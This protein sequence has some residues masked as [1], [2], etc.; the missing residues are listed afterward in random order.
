MNEKRAGLVTFSVLGLAIVAAGLLYRPHRKHGGEATKAPAAAMMRQVASAANAPA[1]KRVMQTFAQ[2]PLSFE[3]E[4]ADGKSGKRFVSRGRGYA[5]EISGKGARLTHKFR[6]AAD[7]A[8]PEAATLGVPLQSVSNIRLSWLGANGGPQVAGGRKQRGQS[9]YLPSKDR[10]TWRQHVAHYGDVRI[11]KLYPGV[12]LKFHGDGQKLEFDYLVAAGADASVVRMGIGTPSLV[13]LNAQGQLEISDNGD[14]LVLEPPVAYQD[15]DGQRKA[16]QAEFVIAAGHEVRFALGDYD[17][18]RALVIDPVLSFA[19]QFGSSSNSS[20]ASDVAVDSTGN[21]YITGT[22]CD[23]DYPV[24]VGVLQPTGGSITNDQCYTGIITKLDPTASS[25]IYSTYIGSQNNITSGIRILPVGSG[26]ALVAGVTTAVDFPTTANA[27]DQTAHGGTCQYGPFLTNKPCTD[28][29][30]LQLSADGSSLVFSTYFGGSGFEVVSS[31]TLDGT[32][33]IY[34]A[35]ATNSADF[36]TTSGAVDTTFGGGVCQNGLFACSDGFVAKFSSDGSKLLES[37]YLGGDD[38]DFASGVALDT[39]GNIYVSGSTNSTNFP[40]TQG[41]YQ[42]THS[43]GANQPDVF[44]AKL[45]PDMKTLTYSTF[46]GGTGFDLGLAVKVDSTGAAYVTGSTGSADFPTTPASFQTSYAGPAMTFCDAELDGSDLNQPSCG[47]IFVSKLNPTGSALVYSTYIGGSGADIA[48]NAALDSSNDFWLLA[49][50]DS[51]DFPYTADAY[52]ASTSENVALVELSPDGK[53]LLFSTPLS[54]GTSG[55]ALALG[56]TIDSAN[57]IYVAGQATQFSPTPGTL[58]AGSNPD[59]FIAKFV[60][61]TARPGVQ[62]SA[63]SVSFLNASVPEG[64]ASAPQSVTL[65]NNGTAPL[66]LAITVPV[67]FGGTPATISEY[68]NCG[69][70]VA[71]GATCTINVV[72]QPPTNTT[73]G[74]GTITITDNAP[75]SPQSILVSGNTGTIDA[76]TFFPS[77]LTFTGQ[78]PGTTSAMQTSGIDTP[79]SQPGALEPFLAGPPTIS[80]PNVAD[81]KIDT[82]NCTVAVASHGCSINVNFAPAANATGTR[83]ASVTV[84]TNAPNSPQ[85]LNLTGTVSGGPFGVF[86]AQGIEVIPTML[87]LTSNNN[88]SVQNTGGAAL[89]ATGFAITG[90][91]ASDFAVTPASCNPAFTLQ[92]QGVCVFELAFT[93]SAHGTRTATLTLTDNEAT[94]AS[95]MVTGYGQD[96]TGPALSLFVSP[97]TGANSAAF[98]GTVLGTTGLGGIFVAVQNTTGTASAQITSTTITGDFAITNNQCTGAIAAGGS[99]TLNV[100]FTPTQTGSRTGI[101]TITTNAPGGQ[102]FTVNFTGTGLVEPQASVTP[103]VL[104]FTS[105]NVGSTSA[106]QT[107]TVKN[108]GNGVL[109]ISN[110]AVTGPFTQTTTCGATLAA[111]ASCTFTVKFAPTV[112]GPGSGTLTFAG[113]A[114]G[115]N[116]AVGLNGVGVTGPSAS[117]SPTSLTFGNQAIGTVSAPQTVTLSNAGS[118]SFA[119]SGVQPSENFAATS[120]CP[121]TLA[122]GAS[123]AI[124]VKFAPTGDVNPGFASGGEVFVTTSAP[125]SPQSIGV[126]GMA[127][128][129]TGAATNLVIVSSVNPSTAGQAVTFTVTVTPT[130]AGG[131]TPTGTISFLDALSGPAEIA[132]PVTLNAQG[133]ASV[134]T[135]TLSQGTHSIFVMYTGDATYAP[136]TSSGTL[137]TVAAATTT[138]VA[139]SQNPSTVGQSVTFTATTTSTAAGTITGSVTFFDGASQIS[140]PVTISGGQ[141]VLAITTLAQGTH[142]ITARYNGGP[143]FAMSTS[144][145]LSQVVNAAGTA[146]TTTTLTSSSNPATKGA[147]VTFTATVTST[148]AGTITG[149]VTFFDG[150]TQLGMGTLSGGKATFSTS[151]LTQGSHNITAQYGGNATFGQSTSSQVVEEINAATLAATSTAVTSSLNP[152]TVGQSVTFTATVT[153]S[154]AGT[155]TGTVAFFDGATQIGMGTLSG[156]L[157]TFVT[158]ALTQSAHSITAQYGGDSNYATSTSPALTQTVNAT[159]KAATS[160]TLTSSVNPSTV[161]QNVTFIATATSTTAGTLTGTISFFDGA[162]QLGS[163]VTISGGM[164]TFS[165]TTLT[166]GTHSIAAKYSGDANFATSTSSAV[167]QVVDS[168]TKATTS[169]AV[170]SAANPSTVGQNVTFT[171]TATSAAA[172]TLTGTISFFDGATQLGAAVT[173]SG[174]MA[175]YATTSL[176]Q[177]TH[178]IT[179]KYS[180]D[181]N[182]ATSTSSTLSQVV[183]AAAKAATIAALASSLNPSTVG[184]SVSFTATITSTTPGTITGAVT[185][186]DGATSIGMGNV[187]AGGV[188]TFATSTLTAGGHSIT[189]QY[190]GDVNY[191]TSTSSALTQT[192]NASGSADFSVSASPGAVTIVAGQSGVVGITVTPVGGSTQTVSF[193]CSGLPVGTAC[194]FLPA[195]VTL[196]GKHAETTAAQISTTARR[197]AIRF[198]GVKPSNGGR[199]TGITV[200]GFAAIFCLLLWL[201]GAGDQSRRLA[202]AVLL[203]AISVGFMAACSGSSHSGMGTPAGTSQ[204]T[205]TA[206]SGSDAHSV[207][208][209]V[210]VQ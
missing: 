59:L 202:L 172:G 33:N 181:S 12:D 127:T 154:T 34:I 37:T 43:A 168:A 13:N 19:S 121:G 38:D 63:T 130:Q 138:T 77:T 131:P 6:R 61:G 165:T 200:S 15:I 29:F 153:S 52:H 206:T 54:E 195:M 72:Y 20:I 180:G 210:T 96:T 56:L 162:T 186:F 35:G 133:K 89:V 204:V 49:D 151:A 128:A 90:P 41:A 75:G 78:G 132:A 192:V 116:F 120:N 47:D 82:S 39:L 84:P 167:S 71:A 99:C 146:S 98:Q 67:P 24:T 171:A 142:A 187:G 179:A 3:E 93:P 197:S 196:D 68:D 92:P 145:A 159:A 140:N 95:I 91:N 22:T 166:Q 88:F 64:S 5:L 126:T 10:K 62:L 198:E 8:H 199:W 207:S 188:A 141:A 25:L 76:A 111:G 60:P 104:N 161:G 135:S 102:V 169:T 136:E 50:T 158:S 69:T 2:L 42:T 53:T 175:T 45:T 107:V 209:M 152:S 177:G 1:V 21:I 134:T 160:T 114:A 51:P 97:N 117:L 108:P 139:S 185:F 191:A 73:G 194:A 65:T 118:A 150:A 44:V 79:A 26:D 156:G 143:V 14:E 55:Q 157:A 81:F 16:V 174:G 103:P 137:Q 125:G 205:I 183:N 144:P 190:G 9:N 189:A 40:V 178:S 155:I 4:R 30:L 119:F 173:I 163:A 70:S 105:Q 129:A 46:I 11:A 147:S 87:G 85:V 17:K 23:T 74:G 164:A 182:F 57:E 83:T 124:S 149:S 110:F 94:P 113:N 184:A 86:P 32:G 7:E 176:T 201:G 101:L 80:G 123:C 48:F 31:M 100:T 18:N 109:N 170:T 106:G 193:A 58:T 122:A 148:T 112:A 66:N 28:D 203:I 115:G 36:P 208:V 27:Y